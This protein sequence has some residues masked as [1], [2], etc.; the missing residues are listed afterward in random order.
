MTHIRPAATSDLSAITALLLE[1]AAQRAAHDGA[2]WPIA[3]DAAERIAQAFTEETKR[4]APVRWLVVETTGKVEGTARLGVIPCPPIYAAAGQ[5][6]FI[7][8]DDTCVSTAAPSNAFAALIAAA[9][10]EGAA[11]GAVVYLAAAALF[12][13][14]KRAA[15]ERSGYEIV[16]HYLV[17]H[18]LA[19]APQPASV[20]AATAADVP[21]IVAM[22]ALSQ[23][24]LH[25]ANARMW[26]PHPEAPA[27]FGLW[28]QHSLTLPDRRLFVST[29]HDKAGF[30]ITQPPSGFHLPLATA[31]GHLGL[32]DDFWAD[33]FATPTPRDA[34][35]NAAA[36]LTA[37]EN[38][39]AERG[40]TSAMAIC[41]TAWPAKQNML[42][43]HGYSDG[44]AWLLK[45]ERRHP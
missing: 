45:A 26:T 8:F 32:I 31:P 35:A 19:H 15:L 13:R 42:R 21:A 44:N 24:A 18:R 10:R 30:V 16:T 27:R 11:I 37:T 6:A 41:P 39:F 12:Q 23:R 28:M 34:A 33:A 36:L 17:K 1:D 2:L 9:E 25:A 14:A 3:P 22:G 20:R 43:R 4:A 40:R 29:A 38:A 5:P 7:L